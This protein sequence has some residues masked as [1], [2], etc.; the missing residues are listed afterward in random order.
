MNRHKFLTALVCAAALAGC[1]VGEKIGPRDITGPLPSARIKF[2][3]FGVSAPAVNFYANTTK[4]TA[5]S[6]AACSPTPTDTMIQRIC[7]EGGQES[8]NG[9]AQGAAAAGGLYAA[10]DPGQYTV[11]GKIS[12]TTDKDL[13]IA[14]VP[15]TIADGKF[16][17]YFVSGIYSTTAKTI[18]AFMIEDALPPAFDYTVAR[19]RFVNAISNSSPMTLFALDTLTKVEVAVGAAVTYKSGGE[20]ASIPAA[21]YNLNTRVTGSATNVITRNAVNFAA[22]RVYTITARG[23]ITVSTAGTSANRPLLDN[24]TNR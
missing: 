5:I 13:A 6:S 20:F 10:I 21:S 18:D 12:A 23:D 2:F 16:Y 19:V 9:V 24:T 14:T 8:I 1:S 22:G 4:F 15:A 11:T 3:N 7:R 17:S